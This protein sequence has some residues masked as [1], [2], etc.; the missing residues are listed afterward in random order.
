MALSFG[1]L[2]CITR[3]YNIATFYSEREA[4]GARFIDYGGCLNTFELVCFLNGEAVT[5]FGGRQIR[6]TENTIEFLPKG[7]AGA[8]YTVDRL[9]H[10][11]C[12]DIYF[13]AATPLPREAC[14][15]QAK[16]G[17]L[18]ALF[19]R[20]ERLWGRKTAGYYAG[21]MSL[22]YEI[23][24]SMQEAGE[25]EYATFAQVAK[26]DKAAVYMKA[27]CFDRDFSYR[28]LAEISGMSYSYFKSLFKRKN[29]VT[30][31]RYVAALKVA[32]AKEL[33]IMGRYTVSQIAEMTGFENV[34]YFS[35]FF[36]KETGV[37]PTQY[38]RQ[39]L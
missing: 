25:N 24:A 37:T 19:E 32:R 22:L 15:F 26:I 8:E 17:R 21:S 12:I 10:G 5:H 20:A 1:E 3:I 18:K 14:A 2:P 39:I 38:P 31:S 11:H 28:R 34:Y 27:A 7:V 23:I 4:G 33:L 29:G 16:G 6:N 9:K 13:D 30:P 36:K 35:S